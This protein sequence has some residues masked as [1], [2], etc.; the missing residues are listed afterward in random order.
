MSS[1]ADRDV[2]RFGM[3]LTAVNAPPGVLGTFDHAPLQHGN[4]PPKWCEPAALFAFGER[5]DQLGVVGK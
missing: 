5:N 1:E 3:E 2:P 4:L